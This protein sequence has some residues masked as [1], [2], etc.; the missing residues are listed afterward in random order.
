MVWLPHTGHRRGNNRSGIAATCRSVLSSASGSAIKRIKAGVKARPLQR[1]CQGSIGVPGLHPPGKLQ[2]RT[3]KRILLSAYQRHSN[4][5][6]KTLAS[7]YTNIAS[8]FSR[9]VGAADDHVLSQRYTHLPSPSHRYRQP[10][11]YI[12]DT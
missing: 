11:V 8:Y 9:Q 7:I 10:A 3:K 2:Y 4:A 1:P 6:I 12:D 5:Y